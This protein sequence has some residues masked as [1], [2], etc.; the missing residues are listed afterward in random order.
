MPLSKSLWGRSKLVGF[1]QKIKPFFGIFLGSNASGDFFDRLA[2]FF[3][4]IFTPIVKGE[5]YFAKVN[6]RSLDNTGKNPF[7][8]FYGDQRF[9]GAY[10]AKICS[11]R[12]LS[13]SKKAHDFNKRGG[14]LLTK[15]IEGKIEDFLALARL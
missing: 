13:S 15:R 7:F 3:V 2:Y 9:L 6:V 4:K 1:W 8:A 11:A 14:I 10:L 12:L 5:E